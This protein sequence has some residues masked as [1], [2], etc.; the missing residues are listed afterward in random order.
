MYGFELYS[1]SSFKCFALRQPLLILMGIWIQ[2]FTINQH[3]G[4]K[5][6]S[7]LDSFCRKYLR[8]WRNLVLPKRLENFGGADWSLECLPEFYRTVLPYATA[9]R[10]GRN[11]ESTKKLI[12]AKAHTAVAVSQRS[13]DWVDVTITTTATAFQ[14]PGRQRLMGST[15]HAALTTA[16]ASWHF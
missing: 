2:T 11:Q 8:L 4:H 15:K 12:D 3:V 1:Q 16:A 13:D 10:N 9:T 6:E 7:A 14:H 5:I